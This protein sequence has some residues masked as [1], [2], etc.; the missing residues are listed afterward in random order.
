MIDASGPAGPVT[1]QGGAGDNVG[2]AQVQVSIMDRIEPVFTRHW[3]FINGP[4]IWV[5]GTVTTPGALE[6]TWSYVF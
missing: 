2:V 4:K 5:P 6:T 1:F 3:G